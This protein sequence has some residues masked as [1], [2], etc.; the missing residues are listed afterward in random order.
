MRNLLQ[1]EVE[2]ISGGSAA[3][4][5]GNLGAT[6]GNVVN[7][8]FQR[9]YGYAPAQS[10]VG[11]ATELGTGIGTIIDSITNPKLIPTAVNDMIQGISDI[12]GVSKANSALVASK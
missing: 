12:V 7:Q 2:E 6:I 8:S 5:F 9:T 1:N 3:T 11:P 10:A 4:V